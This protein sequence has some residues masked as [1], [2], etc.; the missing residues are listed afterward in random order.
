MQVRRRA[1]ARAT[2]SEVGVLSASRTCVEPVACW[3]LCLDSEPIFIGDAGNIHRLLQHV[4][5]RGEPADGVDELHISTRRA[6]ECTLVMRIIGQGHQAA[7]DEL[8]DDS[9]QLL[10]GLT[11]EHAALRM[12]GIAHST[13]D[14]VA[15][16]A[17]WQTA[18]TGV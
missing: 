12:P 17:F 14:I 7:L 5:L 18:T 3:S 6:A 15:H 10:D 8:I 4:G 1:V 13:L 2:G 11:A 9:L 16:F